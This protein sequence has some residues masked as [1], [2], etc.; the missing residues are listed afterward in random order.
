MCLCDKRNDRTCLTSKCERANSYSRSTYRIASLHCKT[1]PLCAHFCTKRRS[2]RTSTQLIKLRPIYIYLV[3][4]RCA[5]LSC[6]A[7]RGCSFVCKEEIGVKR[8]CFV[9]N[10][11]KFKRKDIERGKQTHTHTHTEK[12][13]INSICEQH[14]FFFTVT[15]RVD[16]AYRRRRRAM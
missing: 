11:P 5:V 3:N 6:P 9:Q 14:L 1:N 2:T 8:T 15:A 7:L 16:I 4:E 10:P 13:Y 12:I